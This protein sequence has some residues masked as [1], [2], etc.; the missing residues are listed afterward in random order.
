M[1]L[2]RMD[3]KLHEETGQRSGGNHSLGECDG[4]AKVKTNGGGRDQRSAEPCVPR[5]VHGGTGKSPAQ[6]GI[7]KE[8]KSIFLKI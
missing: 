5:D 6:V 8:Q 1:I 2:I 3:A 7:I 4:G